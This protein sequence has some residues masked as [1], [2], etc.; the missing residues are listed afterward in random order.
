MGRTSFQRHSC[1]V[2]T[3]HEAL[4]SLLN[5]PHPSG[6]L[7]RWGMALQELDLKVVYRRGKENEKADA[8]SRAPLPDEAATSTMPFVQIAPISSEVVSAKDGETLS[9]RQKAD[10]ELQPMMAYLESGIT[11][12][13]QNAKQLILQS[14]EYTL[15][16]GV[17]YHVEKDKTLRIVSPLGD[18]EDLFKAVHSGTF[19]GHLHDAKLHGQLGRH[20]W[21][22]GIRKNIRDWCKA[23]VPCATRNVGRPTHPPLTPIP[24]GG[25]FDR[26]GVDVL[27]F[28]KSTQGNRY[29]VVFVDYL[30]K[31][32]EVFPVPDQTAPTI[33]KLL[34][35]EVVCRHGVPGELLSD[36][37]AAFLSKLVLEVCRL[38]G[39]KKVNTTAY[40]PQTDGLVE[41]FNRTLTDMLWTRMGATEMRSFRMCCLRIVQVFSNPQQNHLSSLSMGE[42]LGYL[43]LM[44]SMSL[45]HVTPFKLMTT[46]QRWWSL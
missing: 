33:A 22:P 8:L 9:Q 41:R 29:A 35:E 2:Y 19:G 23:C 37:G 45:L 15:L 31:W 26:V 20:Y 4:K 36:R 10:P 40:H 21:W 17:L 25:P 13:E 24:V 28:P 44:F 27:Q 12:E 34:V 14:V 11:P 42:M 32:P 39:T 1:T 16:D 7:A 18:R 5:T 3:D 46:S 43:L 30:T 38:M 6:K